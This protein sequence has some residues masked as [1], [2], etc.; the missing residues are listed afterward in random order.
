MVS[1]FF[2]DEVFDEFNHSFVDFAFMEVVLRHGFSWERSHEVV[3]F[4][5][6]ADFHFGT[7]EERCLPETEVFEGHLIVVPAKE[8]HH[9]S[10]LQRLCFFD[11]IVVGGLHLIVPWDASFHLRQEDGGLLFG[12]SG[13][14]RGSP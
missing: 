5:Q 4:R 6:K 11:L 14:I 3:K 7:H 8:E 10:V 1:V 12:D 2:E 13:R 9:A